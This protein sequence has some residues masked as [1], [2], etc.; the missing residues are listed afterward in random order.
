MPENKNSRNFQ[1]QSSLNT[2]L[3]LEGLNLPAEKKTRPVPY[4]HLTHQQRTA[5]VAKLIDFLKSM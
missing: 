1:S 5:L 3:R 4:K 2:A